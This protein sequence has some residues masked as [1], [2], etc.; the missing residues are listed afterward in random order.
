MV[1]TQIQLPDQLAAKLRRM[2]EDQ[3]VSMAGLIRTAITR[4]FEASSVQDVEQRYARAA[5]A[6]GSCASGR[7]D[8]SADHD[9]HFAEASRS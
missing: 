2:A 9:A 8:L 6:A 1:R 4:F 7:G 3:H 5:S